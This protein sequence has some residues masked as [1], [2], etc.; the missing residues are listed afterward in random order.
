LTGIPSFSSGAIVAGKLRVI[1]LIGE[2]GMGA[3]YEVEHTFTKHRRALKML[4]GQMARSPELVARFLREASAAGRIGNPHIVETFDAGRLDAGEPYLVMELLSGRSL[5][6]VIE[7]YGRLEL[8]EAIEVIAQ[9]CEGIQ[10]AHEAGIVHRD[11]KPENL[12]VEQRDGSFVK[13]LDFGI[14]KFASEHTL[15]DSLT[16]QGSL[17]G[18]PF[19]M[20][21]E[22]VRGDKDVDHLADVYALGVVLYECIAGKKPFMA[23]TLPHLSLLIHE[24]KYDPLRASRP[25]VSE[26]LERVVGRAMA[27]DK[28]D[29]F[30]SARE[31]GDALRAVPLGSR[32]A[33]DATVAAPSVA[34][35]FAQAAPAR[36]AQVDRAPDTSAVETRASA[37][38]VGRLGMTTHASAAVSRADQPATP[39]SRG[40]LAGYVLGALAVAGGVWF[41]IQR[42]AALPTTSEPAPAAPPSVA[43]PPSAMPEVTPELTP[44][45]TA[46]MPS[47]APSAAPSAHR[48]L[49][50]ARTSAAPVRTHPPPATSRT[51]AGE[52]GLGSDNPFG[53]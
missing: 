5:S 23:N 50:A 20:P 17:L 46:A 29:R 51:R 13:I 24:G 48:P 19:Y 21:P 6:S 2:G 8:G 32:V 15:S 27:K 47:V 3:V 35:S 52:H 14:S 12:F 7:E 1:R 49:P 11:L 38:D 9:A 40:R 37:P 36:S 31:L 34:A 4:H 10:A 28:S 18:T 16:V 45:E 53:K 30:A 22:Q 44:I 42:G 26:E 41:F 25:E 33:L 39:A 43:P